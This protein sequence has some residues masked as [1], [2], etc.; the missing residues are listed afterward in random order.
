MKV[1]MQIV[2]IEIMEILAKLGAQWRVW[3]WR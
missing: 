1:T 3:E 2:V